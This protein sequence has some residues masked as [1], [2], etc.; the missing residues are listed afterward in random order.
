MSD[1]LNFLETLIT[2]AGILYIQMFDLLYRQSSFCQSAILTCLEGDVCLRIFPRI[3]ILFRICTFV[4][5]LETG[6][7]TEKLSTIK[8][9]R[10]EDGPFQGNGVNKALSSICE[11]AVTPLVAR[12]N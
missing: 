7:I 10:C 4:P 12:A 3:L 6:I 9:D 2:L 5:G 8:A 11:P 1:R